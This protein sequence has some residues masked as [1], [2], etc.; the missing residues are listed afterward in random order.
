MDRASMGCKQR[1]AGSCEGRLEDLD[2]LWKAYC[3]GEE[4]VED[5]GNLNEYGLCFDYV[6]PNTFDDQKEGY[7]RYQLSYG[8][9][10]DEFRFY[11]GLDYT[12][13]KIEYWFMDWN[14]GAKKIVTDN[15]LMQEIFDWFNDCGSCRDEFEKATA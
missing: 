1:V 7:F 11:C 6:A 12:L 13:Y 3:T 14:D 9:P 4:D 2:K 8:G 15:K 10:S 5:L